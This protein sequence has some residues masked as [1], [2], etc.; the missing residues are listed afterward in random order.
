METVFFNIAV[1]SFIASVAC[2]VAA[3]IVFFKL[4][5]LE[6]IRFLRHKSMHYTPPGKYCESKADLF[7]EK[8]EMGTEL[9]EEKSEAATSF[10]D[11]ESKEV[12]RAGFQENSETRTEFFVKNKEESEAGTELLNKDE[13]TSE[14]GTELL[15]KD[16]NTSET[17]TELLD[18]SIFPPIDF[19]DKS[20]GETTYLTDLSEEV[21]SD[22][23]E[24]DTSGFDTYEKE[25]EGVF[26]FVIIQNVVSTHTTDAI[27]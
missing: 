2:V 11:T 16:E 27:E 21:K 22:H 3:A 12:L 1:V 7:Y 17:K 19:P 24:N 10:L 25:E 13:N 4:D 8:S 6:A 15:G 14:A 9:L 20:E 23:T 18:E 5:V 26:R